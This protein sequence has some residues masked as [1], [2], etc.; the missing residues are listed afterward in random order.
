MRTLAVSALLLLAGPAPAALAGVDLETFPRAGLAGSDGASLAALGDVNGDGRA[1]VGSSLQADL[2]D[3]RATSI[4][5]VAVVAF[6]GTPPDPSRPGFAGWVVTHVQEPRLFDDRNGGATGGDIAGVGDFNGDGLGDVAIGAAG[7]GAHGRPNAGSVYV[8]FGRAA[9]GP[10]DVRSAPG[11]VRIDGATR[12]GEIGRVIAPAGDVDGDGLA[13]LVISLAGENAV[14]VRGGLPAGTAIDLAAPPLGTTIPIRGLDG[15]KS[16][17]REDALQPEAIAFVPVGDVDG[18]GR[19]ELLA[20]VPAQ[21]LFRGRGQAFV[22]RGVPAGAA[23]EAKAAL[24]VVSG[25]SERIGLGGRVATVPDTD[26]DGRPEWLIGAALAPGATISIGGGEPRSGAYVVFSRARGAVRLDGKDQPVV[27]IDATGRGQLAGGAIAGVADQTGDGVPDVLIGLPEASPSCRAGAGAIALVPGRRTPGTVRIGRTTPRVDGP[28]VGAGVGE[29]LAA[30]PGELLLGT[31]PFENS[32]RLD[33]WR[34]GLDTI[35]GPSPALPAADDCLRVTVRP[36][37]RAQLVREGVVH[38]RLRSNAGDDR[39]HRLVVRLGVGSEKSELQG[40]RRV[41][42]LS[43]TA[44]RRFTLRLPLR[45][46]KILRGSDLAGVSVSAEQRVGT[47]IR[48]TTGNQGGDFLL[49]E[50]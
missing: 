37:T 1:D 44:S 9:S 29:R 21:D 26:G 48:A 8:V 40:P 15:G 34:V 20:G 47:G 23:I 28:Y 41:F 38:V 45:A 11:V 33:L 30:G 22:L 46:L 14:V 2:T 17:F 19:G 7:A 31:L 42:R 49:F 36:R 16:T 25:P 13:D 10:I 27:L 18:D 50:R 6:G 4:S 3:P 39:P 32:A 12:G 35:R 5:E 43:G 24:A